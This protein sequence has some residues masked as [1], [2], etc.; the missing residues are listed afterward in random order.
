MARDADAF[1]G[2]LT[3]AFSGQGGLSRSDALAELRRYFMLYDSVEIGSAGL[4][5]DRSGPAPVARLRVSFAGKPKDVKGL[6]GMLPETARFQFELTLAE[7]AGGLKVAR[8]AWQ[9]IETTP[10]P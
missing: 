1:G 3:T 7:E 10:N 9:Q 2:H 8:A 4:E 5:L 6:A